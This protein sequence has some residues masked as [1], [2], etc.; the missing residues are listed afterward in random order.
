MKGEAAASRPRCQRLGTAQ[1]RRRGPAGPGRKFRQSRLL[2]RAFSLAPRPF[3][4][5]RG[6]SEAVVPSG[7]RITGVSLPSCQSP[8]TLLER[9]CPHH[10]TGSTS[11]SPAPPWAPAGPGPSVPY[12]WM[13]S[14]APTCWGVG[15]GLGAAGWGLVMQGALR[16]PQSCQRWKPRGTPGGWAMDLESWC[17][18]TQESPTCNPKDLV[19]AFLGF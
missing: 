2:G 13:R 14:A 1:T 16:P 5:S 6:L 8:A 18:S 10:P 4:A 11:L 9:L 19:G 15:R 12:R 17:L 3:G 7:T